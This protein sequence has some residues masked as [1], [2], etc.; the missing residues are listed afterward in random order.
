M[1]TDFHPCMLKWAPGLQFRG[2]WRAIWPRPLAKPMK[3]VNL[4]Q[5]SQAP[6]QDSNRVLT[7]TCLN[8][9]TQIFQDS[10][11]PSNMVLKAVDAEAKRE[12]FTIYIWYFSVPDS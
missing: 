12:F 7:V 8:L 10:L 2:R 9:S 4:C 3:Y 5:S 1:S 6:T 11:Q